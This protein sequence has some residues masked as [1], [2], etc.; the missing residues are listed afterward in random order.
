MTR[1][2]CRTYIDGSRAYRPNGILFASCTWVWHMSISLSPLGSRLICIC[3]VQWACRQYSCAKVGFCVT[4]IRQA[5]SGSRLRLLHL[6]GTAL[7]RCGELACMR[8]LFSRRFC[9]SCCLNASSGWQRPALP[10]ALC[11]CSNV[12]ACCWLHTYHRSVASHCIPV[13]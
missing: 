2:R 11:C 13:K 7:C 9:Q 12:P 8:A 5:R 10:Q 1:R 3:S 4:Y 6:T